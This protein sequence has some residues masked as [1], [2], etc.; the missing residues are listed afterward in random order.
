MRALVV[1][2]ALAAPAIAHAETWDELAARAR[3]ARI[4]QVAWATATT[5]KRADAVEERQCKQLRDRALAGLR[6][7][8]LIVAIEPE[9]LVV[10]PWN[11]ATQSV[12]LQLTGCLRC[13]APVDVDGMPWTVQVGA[14]PLYDNAKQFSSEATATAWIKALASTRGEAIVRIPDK[15][16]ASK[17]TLTLELFG[18][19]VVT[20]C[21]GGVVIASP[22]AQNLVPDKAACPR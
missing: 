10:G 18:Y 6:G 20:P 2:L 12:A 8:Q 14:A 19:R 16:D 1:A 3:P 17:P 15:R 7:Q 13:K 4:E 21:D 5:C 11:Q 9:A 22:A